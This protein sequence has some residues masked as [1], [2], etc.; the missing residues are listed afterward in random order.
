VTASVPGE[1]KRRE[2]NRAAAPQAGKA[3]FPRS[4]RLLRHADFERVYK[5]GRRHFSAS[6]TAFYLLRG[7][8]QKAGTTL[9]PRIGFTVGRALGGAVQ[10]NR[11]KRR[12][13]EAVRLCGVPGAVSVDVVINPKKSLLTIDFAAVV[14]EVK[15]AF[16]VIEQKLGEKDKSLNHEGH[17]G[18]RRKT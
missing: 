12:L 15:R 9:G 8:E 14:N 7:Q 10:R 11:M 3:A 16:V 4:A 1:P 18:S 17:E 6:L 2:S 13:R 5:L